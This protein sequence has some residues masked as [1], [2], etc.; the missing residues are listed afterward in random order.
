MPLK[1]LILGGARSGKS[2]L[3]ETLAARSGWPVLYL[4]TATAGD[5]EM[6]ERIASHRRRRPASWAT[7]E[8]SVH[9]AGAL[10]REAGPGRCVLVD[11]LTLWLSSLLLLDGGV[12]L[13]RE[14]EALIGAIEGLP[15]HLIMVSNEVGMG[16]VPLGEISRRFQDE[17]GWLHQSLA[18]RCDR[19]IVTVAGLPMVLK[20]DPL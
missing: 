16:I 12:H 2:R 18:A 19:V 8:E 3:A 5:R 9:L 7:L 14:T 17:A 10:L 1:E 20:G 15:G 13:K 6:S 4:A 11:C